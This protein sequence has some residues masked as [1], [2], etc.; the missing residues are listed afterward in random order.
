VLNILHI[1]EPKDVRRHNFIKEK[2]TLNN[3]IEMID[4]GDLGIPDFQRQ[5]NWGANQVHRA[6]PAH[7]A[8]TR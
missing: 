6:L 3:L 7:R 2:E 5:Y 1:D 8:K 4:Y